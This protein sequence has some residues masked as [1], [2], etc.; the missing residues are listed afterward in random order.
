MSPPPGGGSMEHARNPTRVCDVLVIGSGLAG[1]CA[2][3]SAAEAGCKVI[4]LEQEAEAGG[5]ALVDRAL[6]SWR[7]DMLA[8]LAAAPGVS[9]LTRHTATEALVTASG[10]TAIVAATA[11]PHGHAGDTK[12]TAS[13]QRHHVIN[14][15]RILLAT[16]A[17]ERLISLS[18][19]DRPGVMLATAARASVNRH[20]TVPGQRAVFFVNNDE[21]YAAVRD[22][23][24]AAIAIGA[25]VDPR[26]PT[27]ISLDAQAEGLTVL[28]GHEVCAIEGE[29]HG[30]G[31]GASTGRAASVLVREIGSG[32]SLRIP[33]DLVCL[34][35]GYEP[36]V[37]LARQAGLQVHWNDDIAGFAA[38]AAG[39]IMVPV[40]AAAGVFGRLEAAR[41]GQQAGQASAL[42]CGFSPK[43]AAFL[44]PVAARRDAPILPLEHVAHKYALATAGE[45]TGFADPACSDL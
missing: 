23:A 22:L 34:S 45:D 8:A 30:N 4:V 11:A 37:S 27:A 18:G 31:M 42:A 32:T 29:G 38:S 7:G 6:A 19:H 10:K 9:L 24:A 40:G 3:R 1:L 13:Q 20:A 44:P 15:S 2:A 36:Q 5:G 28:S 17:T 35:G 43:P 16:G 14:A 33:C 12:D 25:V 39:G 26:P 21:A 41:H